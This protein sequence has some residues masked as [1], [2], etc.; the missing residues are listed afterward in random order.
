M[1]NIADIVAGQVVG[2]SGIVSSVAAGLESKGL[3]CAHL[4]V[5]NNGAP[6][7]WASSIMSV[8]DDTWTFPSGMKFAEA[9]GALLFNGNGL[10]NSSL[11]RSVDCP[12]AHRADFVQI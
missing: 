1:V 5:F 11:I 7:S 4:F 10:A 2:V 8:Y 3:H 6:I 12:Q 9:I